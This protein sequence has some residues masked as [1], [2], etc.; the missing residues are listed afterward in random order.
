MPIYPEN[1]VANA[2]SGTI[3]V[4]N[5]FANVTLPTNPFALEGDKNFVIRLRKGGVNGLVIATS[6][7]ITV[8]DPSQLVSLTSNVSTVAE[9][10]LVTFTLVTAN[11]ANNSN[12]F[13]SVF[14]VTANV[15]T[16]DFVG[17]NVGRATIINNQAT[18][19]F[20]ANA[21][22][23]LMD[24]TNET[25]RVQLRENS[26][27]GNIIFNTSNVI[28]TDVSK[29][30]NVFG[31]VESA[32]SIVEG[33]SVTFT[34]SAQNLATGTLLYYYTSGNADITGANTGSIAMNSVSNTITITSA[35]TVPANQSR[36][37]SLVL[38]ESSL[39]SPIATSNAITV[40]DSALAYLNATGGTVSSIDGFRIHTFTSSNTFGI[41]NLS[42]AALKTFDILSVAGGGGG[43][44]G[45][46]GGGGGGGFVFQPGITADANLTVVIGAGGSGA[47]ISAFKFGTNTTVT[48]GS[49]NIISVGGGGA[50]S[51]YAGGNAATP[52][53]SGG[54]G[55]SSVTP[56]VPSAG[57][58][59]FGF[60]S[61]TQQGFPGSP[62][63]GGGGGAGQT[64]FNSGPPS[65][66]TGNPARGGNGRPSLITG[67]NVIYAGGGGGKGVGTSW[68][69]GTGGGGA[70]APENAPYA[71]SGTPGT[72]N[73]G[74]GGGAGVEATA[75]P[76][77]NGGSGIVIIR[78]QWRPPAFFSSVTAN[79]AGANA[80]SN[81]FFVVNTAFAN[82]QIMYY[83]TVGDVTTSN[84]VG[85]N[86]GSFTI[87][88]NATVISLVTTDSIPAGEIRTFALRI[89]EDSVTGNIVLISSNVTLLD[90]NSSIYISATGG[91]VFTEGGFRTHIFTSSN[92]FAVT[93]AGIFG[94][95]IEYFMVAGGGGGGRPVA[96]AGGGGGAGGVLFG[97]SAVIANTYVVTVGGGG[98]G[99]ALGSV[100]P[101][102]G[103][104]GNTSIIGA[105]V[106]GPG[107][108]AVGGGGAGGGG[109]NY[110]N[111]N[112]VKPGVSGGS[113]GGGSG[114]YNP[115]SP[116][117]DGRAGGGF[118]FPGTIGSTMQGFPGGVGFG[119]SPATGGAGGG[120][121]GGRAANVGPTSISPFP[122]G[123]PGPSG[124]PAQAGS[125]GGIGI[126]SPLSSTI[127][128]FFGT[129]G[130]GPGRWFAGGGG[131]GGRSGP[132]GGPTDAGL[133][134]AGGGGRG[135]YGFPSPIGVGA[136]AG[137]VNTGGGGGGGIAGPEGESP[138][139]SR[140]GGSGIVIIRYP[141]A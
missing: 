140:S 12:V 21:D 118:G 45:R 48:G 111:P 103:S 90:A 5:G 122:G 55:T 126:S 69:G 137:N 24:E 4:T 1:F 87:T 113:G 92:N 106:I 72:V 94:G 32:S 46:G 98:A 35:A 132:V 79:V 110:S 114:D 59:G 102:G 15:N 75:S 139:A 67:A 17:A 104:G 97:T 47:N 133:G 36:S 123:P 27:T 89:R 50:G 95:N 58:G 26:P 93:S 11:A 115:T 105:T 128:G 61:P 88:S 78:Y 8:R 77:G 84:F 25:F 68:P 28:I 63:G 120:G 22:L 16:A 31:F 7:T 121:A 13:Y 83:D 60:P 39:G 131:G 112:S 86:T 116:T 100:N 76:G 53:G 10:N 71:P 14:P 29:R 138:V 51:S 82:A 37:F 91:N 74:G 66:P 135:A 134:G 125:A 40:V 33:T 65:A 96:S 99:S 107:V 127:P 49:V 2:L 80:G 73:T 38:S 3:L 52:G 81:V 30:I 101:V 124:I 117:T 57:G 62:D 34:V 42:T 9:G 141:Y 129:P 20:F 136:N 43:G 70:S 44:L 130:P 19:T 41:T 108:V 54:G 109:L 6:P 64:G 56:G 23:S 18:F 85:G 119:G